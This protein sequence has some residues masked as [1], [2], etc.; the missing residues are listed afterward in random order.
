MFLKIYVYGHGPEKIKKSI[1]I[2]MLGLCKMMSENF[3]KNQRFY[4]IC[5]E[6]QAL[7]NLRGLEVL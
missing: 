6:S 3:N 5:V 4:K 1:P 7:S 2:A